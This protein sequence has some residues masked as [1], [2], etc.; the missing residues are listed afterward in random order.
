MSEGVKRSKEVNSIV[1]ISAVLASLA[2]GVLSAYGIC[3]GM[4]RVF[5]MHAM[6]VAAERKARAMVAAT[7]VVES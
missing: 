6:Q 4:F 5:R 3:V 1:L 7:P 2:A